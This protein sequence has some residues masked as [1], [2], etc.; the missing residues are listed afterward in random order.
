[1]LVLSRKKSNKTFM[2][3]PPSDKETVITLVQVDIQGDRSKIGIDAPKEVT[4]MREELLEKMKAE[5]ASKDQVSKDQE[6]SKAA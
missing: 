4:I 3:V 1:M 5:E 6:I 2:T